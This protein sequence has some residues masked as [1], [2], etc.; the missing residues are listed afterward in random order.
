HR[1]IW[2]DS[3]HRVIWLNSGH[4]VTWLDS[5][6]RVIRQIGSSGWIGSSGRI[7]SSGIRASGWTTEGGSSDSRLTGLDT[8]R[9]VVVGKNFRFFLG[10]VTGAL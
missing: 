10:L 3:G 7:G 4:R 8:G 9:M 6:H 5:G 1:V 2:L